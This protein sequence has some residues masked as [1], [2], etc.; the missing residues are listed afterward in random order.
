MS[1]QCQRCFGK[2]TGDRWK[3]LKELIKTVPCA[4]IIPQIV[5]RNPGSCKD[6]RSTH[7]MGISADNSCIQ[8]YI[9][10]RASELGLIRSLLFCVACAGK[11]G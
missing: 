7:N 11:G 10:F 2:L 6:K 4:K 1:H 3:A 9:Q 8:E 5:N